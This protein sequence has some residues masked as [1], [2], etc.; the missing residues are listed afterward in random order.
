MS[1]YESTRVLPYVYKL[2]HKTTGQFYFGYRMKNVKMGNQ[3]HLDLGIIYFSSSETVKS[4]GYENFNYEIVMTCQTADDAYDQENLLIAQ[5]F[6]NP[7]CLNGTYAKSGGLRFKGKD[8]HT[9]ETIAK[10]IVAQSNRSPETRAKLGNSHRNKIVSAETR[11]KQSAAAKVSVR[12]PHSQET[13]D[14]IK[15]S[16]VDNPKRKHTPE[17]SKILS[18][19]QKGA[20]WKLKSHTPESRAKISATKT[21]KTLSP[22]SRA[23]LIESRHQNKSFRS[24]VLVIM[25]AYF[26]Y[27]NELQ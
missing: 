27:L 16:W 23:R 17:K 24:S 14:K 18:Q 25:L 11:A 26:W 10:M 8:K 4:M 1:I 20:P 5:H 3:A 12:P 13:I 21:G 7:L 15:A 19:A 6:T 2:T 9:P 22:E